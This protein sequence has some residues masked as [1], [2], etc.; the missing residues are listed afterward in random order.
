[1]EPLVESAIKK[2]LTL[3]YDKD[4]NFLKKMDK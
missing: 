4:G 2:A 3:V 1:M